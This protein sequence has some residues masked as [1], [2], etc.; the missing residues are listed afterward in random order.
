MEAAFT[1]RS[2]TNAK[3]LLNL[4]CDVVITLNDG[5]LLQDPSSALAA[6]LFRPQQLK[7]AAFEEFVRDGDRGRFRAFMAR[8]SPSRYVHLHLRDAAGS[9]G[10][11]L[12]RI[13]GQ[14]THLLSVRE[15]PDSQHMRPPP[16]TD[17]KEGSSVPL[18]DTT[19]SSPSSCSDDFVSLQSGSTDML[20]CSLTIPRTWH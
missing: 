15:E 14:T 7:D 12:P 19:T 8:T 11:A 1:V 4:V 16:S 18:Q 20:E 6:R 13:L 3:D 9:R 10:A 2:E 5:L 17:N